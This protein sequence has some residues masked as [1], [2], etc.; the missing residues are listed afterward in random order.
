MTNSSLSI[1]TKSSALCI[2]IIGSSAL[3]VS[4]SA[5]D[6]AVLGSAR[7]VKI[8]KG[9]IFSAQVS[10]ENQLC[11]LDTCWTPSIADV[12]VL[13]ERLGEFLADS[14]LRGST[15]I[16]QNLAKYKRK[17]YGV[18]RNGVR[19]IMVVGICEKFW[20]DEGPLFES[21][22]RPATDLGTCYFLVD[23]NVEH[24]SFSDYYVD[25]EA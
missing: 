2:S 6:H 16:Q 5:A 18:R 12:D 4:Q 17:Y 13:E 19:F 7:F 21:P 10:Q 3:A 11:K 15:E 23:Y 8:S 22:R 24:R 1:L 25:G 9:A 14:R 20:R